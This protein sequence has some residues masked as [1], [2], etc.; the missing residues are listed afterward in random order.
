MP[1]FVL[2]RNYVL[3]HGAHC[4]NFTKGQPTW[5]PP[6][7]VKEAAKIGAEPVDG[8]SVDILDNEKPEAIVLSA[9][10]RIAEMVTAIQ[11]ICEK[12]DTGDFGG[13]NRPTVAAVENIVPFKTSKK[14]IGVAWNEYKAKQ[15]A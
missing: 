8:S 13:D 15:A 3:Q 14:E 4:L 10:E 5:V 2:N 7:L 11:M 12:N 6:A 9:E 1:E